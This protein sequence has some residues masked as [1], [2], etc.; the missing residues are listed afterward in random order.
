MSS[1]PKAGSQND[2]DADQQCHSGDCHGPFL[3][4]ESS[5]CRLVESVVIVKNSDCCGLIR[6]SAPSSRRPSAS[7]PHQSHLLASHLDTRRP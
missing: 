1:V 3:R 6:E 7:H 2:E 5:E 4:G